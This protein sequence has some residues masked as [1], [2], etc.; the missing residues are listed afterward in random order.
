MYD[1]SVGHHHGHTHVHGKGRVLFVALGLTAAF[2]VFEAIAGFRAGSLA[3]LSD[4]GHNFTDAFA[5]LLAAIGYYLQSRPAD[6]VKTYG[7]QRAGVLAASAAGGQTATLSLRRR[8][9]GDAT[10]SNFAGG[11]LPGVPARRFACAGFRYGASRPRC[12]PRPHPRAIRELA[13]MWLL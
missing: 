1:R 11:A 3:L 9:A 6:H 7:Y 10:S 8:V 4:A 12:A 5:L 2:V 13:K